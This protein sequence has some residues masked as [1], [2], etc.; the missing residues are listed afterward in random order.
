MIRDVAENFNTDQLALRGDDYRNLRD[1]SGFRIDIPR[2]YSYMLTPSFAMSR[3]YLAQIQNLRQQYRDVITYQFRFNLRFCMDDSF[4]VEMKV[5]LVNDAMNL[6]QMIYQQIMDINASDNDIMLRIPMFGVRSFYGLY[7]IP[8]DRVQP[9]VSLMDLVFPGDV[10]NLPVLS[11][12]NRYTRTIGEFMQ[13]DYNKALN[14]FSNNDPEVEPAVID[15]EVEQFEEAGVIESPGLN[16]NT[17][18]RLLGQP[19]EEHK[20]I[21][22]VRWTV[23]LALNS[24]LTLLDEWLR[25]TNLSNLPD[26]AENVRRWREFLNVP[27]PPS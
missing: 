6:I 3:R 9:G 4:T 19:D 14:V 26:T 8:N 21:L 16:L 15:R 23:R 17:L 11:R 13:R 7:E 12:Y 25:N 20:K 27:R 22:Y 5:A 18:E 10:R 1:F 2:Q 24:R